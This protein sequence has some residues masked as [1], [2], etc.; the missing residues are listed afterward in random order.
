MTK[1]TVGAELLDTCSRT[2]QIAAEMLQMS[3]STLLCGTQTR[4]RAIAFAE[5]QMWCGE[6]KTRR[7][8]RSCKVRV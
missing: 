6:F 8:V 7:D 3:I 2:V 1:A 4:H 5:D